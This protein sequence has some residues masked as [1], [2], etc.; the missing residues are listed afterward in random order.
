MASATAGGSLVL[1]V[2]LGWIVG[3][4]RFWGRSPLWGL[5]LV[6]LAAGP[7][8]VAP[9]ISLV[10]GG[11]RGWDWLAARSIL[12]VSA[13]S[14]V[15]WAALV[16]I[17]LASGSPLVALATLAGLRRV[18]PSWTEAARAVGASRRRAWRDVV[19]PILRPEA[20]R[21]SARWSSRLPW[22]SRP[23]RWS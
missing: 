4:W 20:A 12:G 7:L 3:R 11:Q 22:S 8:L 18:D 2:G 1:G 16:G 15:R 21:A 23:G 6:P 17:G 19:W 10:L 5:A 14:S 9:G 13:E